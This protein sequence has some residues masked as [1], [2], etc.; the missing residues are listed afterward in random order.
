MQSQCFM[1][2]LAASG[3]DRPISPRVKRSLPGHNTPLFGSAP[4]IESLEA[5]RLF[6]VTAG[7]VS[8]VLV[9]TG[10][11]SAETITAYQIDAATDQVFIDVNG[12][13][14][15]LGPF[16]V[17]TFN[18]ISMLGG[19]GND[20]LVIDSSVNHQYGDMYVSKPAQ[21]SGE[22]GDDTLWGGEQGDTLSGGDGNDELHGGFG[23]DT[24]YGD[25]GGDTLYGDA[26]NDYLYGGIDE[27]DLHG[28]ADGDTLDGV[29]IR[30]AYR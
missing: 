20:S 18:S 2:V 3:P 1:D 15:D 26:G 4:L 21:I 22:V 24:L 13:G 19:D 10:T 7:V 9:V 23:S 28:G 25:S 8:N 5:R 29:R 14:G 17:N 27:D 30:H 6:A 11:S 12:T 16:A